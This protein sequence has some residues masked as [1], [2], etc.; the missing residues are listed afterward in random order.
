MKITKAIVTAASRRQRAL[1]L[2]T[3]IDRDGV[4]KSVLSVLVEEV[5][6]SGIEET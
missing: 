5:L 2:Q 4:E 3:L 6:R 1:P